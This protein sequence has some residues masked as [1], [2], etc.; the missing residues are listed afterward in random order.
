MLN[1]GDIDTALVHG[2]DREE[3]EQ[4]NIVNKLF[5]RVKSRGS[6]VR[7]KDEWGALT[8]NGNA[9]Q[10]MCLL[11][12]VYVIKSFFLRAIR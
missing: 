2:P 9:F 4:G 10:K 12:P 3:D 1:A 6:W 5:H 11:L 7:L 8:G